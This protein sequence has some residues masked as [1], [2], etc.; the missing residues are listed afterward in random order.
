[1]YV[2]FKKK[3]GDNMFDISFE[4]DD[5]NVTSLEST[6]LSYTQKW[7]NQQSNFYIN[8]GNSIGDKEFHERFL[9]YYVSE[10]EFFLKIKKSDK[11]I[12]LLKGRIEFKNNNEVWIWYFI[13]D[14]NCRGKE[15]GS[16]ILNELCKYFRKNY[17]IYDFYTGI[18]DG[19]KKSFHFWN[20]NNFALFRISEDYFSTENKKMNM[21]I[22]KNSK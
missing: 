9:E 17:G 20:K 7:L 10:G 1:M 6:D 3:R 21:L 18:I 13:V 2:E 19:D 11:L 16:R 22:L 5:I 12:G 8:G 15:I 4:F 14:S